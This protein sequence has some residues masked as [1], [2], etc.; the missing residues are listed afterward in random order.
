ML[1]FRPVP[2]KRRKLDAR[3]VL[4]D[5]VRRLLAI[6][7]PDE[8][9]V[10]VLALC[11]EFTGTDEVSLL[12]VEGDELVEHEIQRKSLRREK[13][14]LKI[15][16]Q[17][18]VGWC[19]ARK[20]SAVVPDVRKDK[21]YF[22]ANPGTR[23]EAA[24]PIVQGDRLVGVLN[25][26][27]GKVGFFT[28]SDQ[29]LLELLAAQLAVGLRLDA[30]HRRANRLGVQ[31]GMLN[32]LGRA[33]TTLGPRE[34]LQRVTD[35]V[36]PTFGGSYAAICMGDYRRERV[37][38]LAQSGSAPDRL[39][40]PGTVLPFGKGM[41]GAAFRLGET[42]NAPDVRRDPNYF[43]HISET[44]SEIDVPIRAGDHCLGIV[45][46]QSDEIAAFDPEDAQTL[47]TLARSLVPVLQRVQGESGIT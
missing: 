43:A 32:H 15:G 42:V 44:R 24:V 2:V 35:L 31:L 5:L 28:T 12:L 20:R 19:A 36:R 4:P 47:D 40:A 13:F 33:G 34:F 10:R 37:V 21:R 7:D 16:A 9:L 11:R 46:V 29:D 6:G 26:E 8:L 25:F 27:S 22:E 45:D 38:I 30:V 23:S 41:I 1:E 39:V 3:K 17:G 14:R 18:L